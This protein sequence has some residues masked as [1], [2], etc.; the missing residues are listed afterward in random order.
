MYFKNAVSSKACLKE[1]LNY[2]I[3]FS[4][5]K[6]DKNICSGDGEA[7]PLSKKQRQRLNAQKRKMAEAADPKAAVSKVAPPPPAPPANARPKREA[8]K[9]PVDEFKKLLAMEHKKN[10]THY[11]SSVGCGFGADCKFTHRCRQCNGHHSAHL[12]HK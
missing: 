7:P 4:H 1:V 9:I 12:F 8:R 10:C 11:N 2:A 5:H 6:I 3:G